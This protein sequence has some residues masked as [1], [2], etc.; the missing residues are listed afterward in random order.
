[1]LEGTASK[2]LKVIRGHRPGW[3]FSQRDLADI[4]ARDAVDKALQRLFQ[5]GTIRRIIRG[6]YDYPR[7][8]TLL[9]QELSPDTDQAAQALARKFRW[10][11]QPNGAAAQNLLGLSTLPRLLPRFA[12]GLIPSCATRF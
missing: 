12:S 5:K 6:L 11:I 4:G 10:R 2:I 9:D 7:F 3:A 1:M 8:S